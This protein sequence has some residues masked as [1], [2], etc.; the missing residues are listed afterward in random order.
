MNNG[1]FCWRLDRSRSAKSGTN[2]TFCL[3]PLP[4]R[5]CEGRVVQYFLSV[6]CRLFCSSSSASQTTTRHLFSIT[7]KSKCVSY[8][9]LVVS[10]LALARV[11]IFSHPSVDMDQEELLLTRLYT[12][13][14]GTANQHTPRKA[15]IFHM[16]TSLHDS[17][18]GWS[19]TQ[20]CRPQGYCTSRESPLRQRVLPL[21]TNTLGY[22]DRSLPQR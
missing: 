17:F 3:W 5:E 14:I 9:F 10:F 21:T 6:C 4:L 16:L 13:I 8:L 15:S 19:S 2:P 7:T 12:G 1:S 20:D 11:R 22:Q 18:L